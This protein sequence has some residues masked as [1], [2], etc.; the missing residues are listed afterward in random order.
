MGLFPKREPRA[1]VPD[2]QRRPG[3][4]FI[5]HWEGRPH[6]FDVALTSPLC[7]SNLLQ[8]SNSTGAALENMKKAKN[9]KHF[10]SCRRQ[11]IAIMPLVVKTLG[12]W[13]SES[14][15][16]LAKIAEMAAHR[17]SKRAADVKRHF[18]Q[19]LSVLLQRANL[20]LIATRAPPP[21]APHVPGVE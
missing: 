18:F 17:S 7:A 12:G 15:F 6:D 4:V 13:D 2:W 16:D 14:S 21:P 3:D 8:A 9:G 1:L 5:P 20:S 11:G 19:R 10:H